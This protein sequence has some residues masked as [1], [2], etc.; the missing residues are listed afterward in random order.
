M[1]DFDLL[2]HAWA[3]K[4]HAY[5]WKSQ[6]AVGCAIATDKGWARVGYNVEGLWM[7]SIHAE[8]KAVCEVLGHRERGFKIAIVAETEFFTPCG[9]CLD[10]LMQACIPNA[11]VLIQN[12]M[13][14]GEIKRFRLNELC[15]YYPKQ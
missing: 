15:P 9:A 12:K 7:T 13:H 14:D 10:W 3:A 6:T 1:K 11:D 5:P 2:Q 4:E 8:A